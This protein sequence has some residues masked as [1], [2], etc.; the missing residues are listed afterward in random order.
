MEAGSVDHSIETHGHH[1]IS[2]VRAY[3]LTFTGLLGL[4]ILT[5]VTAYV[6][7]GTLSIPVMLIIAIGKASLILLFFMH[8]RYSTGLVWVFGTLGF[9]FV[10]ILFLISMGDYIARQ[11]IQGDQSLLGL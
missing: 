7:L 4:M 11:T 3:L 5:V 6:H 9:F 10:I 2:P 8:L 1:Y